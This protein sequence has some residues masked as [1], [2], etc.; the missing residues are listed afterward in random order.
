MANRS[1][2]ISILF[3]LGTFCGFSQAIV[4]GIVSDKITGESLIGANVLYQEG[5]GAATDI[6][7]YFEILIPKGTYSIEFSYVGYKNLLKT[8]IV[9][10]EKVE[11]N[12]QLETTTLTEVEVVADIAIDRKTPV[13]FTNILPKKLERE[14]ASQ[15]IPMLLNSTPGVFASKKF[16]SKINR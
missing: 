12:V 1:L 6:N 15:D 4:T 8:I 5:K 16:T 9:D 7:G 14:L 13:A 10:Q 11:L 2:L 3:F